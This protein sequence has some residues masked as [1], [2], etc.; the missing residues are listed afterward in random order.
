MASAIKRRAPPLMWD[1]VDAAE[2]LSCI[3]L[4]L[5]VWASCF[6]ARHLFHLT[7]DPA[8]PLLLFVTCVEYRC[9]LAIVVEFPLRVPR[10]VFR[11]ITLLV[12]L[13]WKVL[14]RLVGV[15][16]CATAQDCRQS[17]E[18]DRVAVLRKSIVALGTLAQFEL[19]V[20]KEIASARAGGP[21]RVRSEWEQA[22]IRDLGAAPDPM[23]DFPWAKPR[24][25]QL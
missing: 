24:G 2:V 22:I 17:T 6:G 10:L 18:A 16:A 4:G 5:T 23:F 13:P 12:Q 8:V 1:V 3:L 20:T 7:L 25:R 21:D 19:M 14:R 15:N 11:V 9:L